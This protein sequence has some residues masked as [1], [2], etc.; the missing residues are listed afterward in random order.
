MIYTYNEHIASF[1]KNG[2]LRWTNKIG[3]LFKFEKRTHTEA[4]YHSYSNNINAR[5]TMPDDRKM[6]KNRFSHFQWNSQRDLIDDSTIII[7]WID[8][9][10]HKT[11]YRMDCFLHSF[12][13]KKQ[14]KT[15]EVWKHFSFR[16]KFKIS[17]Q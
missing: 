17:N 10:H 9:I 16:A 5:P 3:V 4:E 13:T 2:H 15:K 8:I 12:P 7:S 1:G 6:V 14:L 11:G